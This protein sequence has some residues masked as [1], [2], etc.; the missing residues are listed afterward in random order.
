MKKLGTV[1]AGS[2]S[3]ALLGGCGTLV[4]GG[5][6]A[7]GYDPADGRTHQQFMADA[8]ISE[9]VTTRLV[10]DAQV[11]AMDI[12][13]STYR[14]VV[15]L[16]GAVRDGHIARRAVTLAHGVPGVRRVVSNLKV[17]R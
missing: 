8:N 6:P 17:A 1:V 15:T 12:R 4:V 2:L 9:A 16:D 11:N 7:G 3:L 14:G 5:A 13:V 10:H